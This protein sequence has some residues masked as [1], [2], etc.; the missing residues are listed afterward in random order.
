MVCGA[1]VCGAMVCGV[2]VCGAMVCG[3]MVCGAILKHL[4]PARQA[5]GHLGSITNT[6]DKSANITNVN[7]TRRTNKRQPA[8]Q[9]PRPIKPRGQS[10]PE[11]NQAP[12]PIKRTY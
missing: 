12:R 10:S 8:H 3:V 4:W 9:A 2:M 5:W 11:A 7:T 1:M 6:K